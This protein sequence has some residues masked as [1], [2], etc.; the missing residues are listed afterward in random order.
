MT[1]EELRIENIAQYLC[2]QRY[3]DKNNPQKCVY[4]WALMQKEHQDEFREKAK[5]FIAKTILSS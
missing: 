5:I 1:D 3:P 2:L 4:V